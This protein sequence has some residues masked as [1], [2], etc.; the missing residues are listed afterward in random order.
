MNIF[1]NIYI[2]NPEIVTHPQL[3]SIPK[4]EELTSL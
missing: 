1:F 2:S 3:K 4:F